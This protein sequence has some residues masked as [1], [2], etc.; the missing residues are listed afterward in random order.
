MLTLIILIIIIFL[1]ASAVINLGIRR[2]LRDSHSGNNEI[3]PVSV[4]VALKNEA[5]NIPELIKSLSDLNYSPDLLEFIF[6]DDNSTDSTISELEKN[7][8]QLKYLKIISADEKRFTGKKGALDIG[9][10]SS[11]NEYILI[12]DADC[13]VEKN[14]VHA[15]VNKFAEDFDFVFGIAPFI[16][17]K[18]AANIL[19]CFDNFKSSL[20]TFS[21]AGWGTPY[22]AAARSFGYKRSSFKKVKGYENTTDVLSGDDDLLLREAIKKNMNVGTVTSKDAF[23]YSEGAKTFSEFIKRKTRHTKTSHKY[24]FSSQLFLGFWHLINLVMLFSIVLIPID[25]LFFL[26]FIIKIISDLTT[27]IIYQD[28]FGYKFSLAEIFIHQILYEVFLIV[29]FLFSLLSK[30]EWK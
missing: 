3:L 30:D 11:T 12:T 13:R 22:S 15:F 16:K 2:S 17:R 29:N 23:V 26:P 28:K 25:V 8:P 6:I 19:S 7:S 24:L 20:L 5:E 18:S 27:T 9:V 14:W 1:S 21:A 4:V 10:A